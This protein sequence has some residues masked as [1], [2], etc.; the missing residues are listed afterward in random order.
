VR[1]KDNY[2]G[3][4]ILKPPLEDHKRLILNKIYSFKTMKTRMTYLENYVKGLYPEI[5]A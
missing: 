1:R 2:N 4:L 3:G 5:Y